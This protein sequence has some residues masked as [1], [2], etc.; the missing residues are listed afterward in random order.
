MDRFTKLVT[1]LT[2]EIV[3]AVLLLGSTLSSLAVAIFFPPIF[4][5]TT[6]FIVA[7]MLNLKKRHLK[8]I[9]FSFALLL[10]S[11][12][13]FSTSVGFHY[14][15]NDIDELFNLEE[16]FQ[17]E[18]HLEIATERLYFLDEK[19]SHWIMLAGILG[20]FLSVLWWTL[21]TYRERKLKEDFEE[22]KSSVIVLFL[23]VFF[24]A[25]FG[26]IAALMSVEAHVLGY[27]IIAVSLML[28]FIIFKLRQIVAKDVVKQKVL[29]F[30][31]MIGAYLATAIAYFI[32][33]KSVYLN[34]GF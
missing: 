32:L 16:I 11:I 30:S 17:K 27:G 12:S 18:M 19:F 25:L 2:I 15:A 34:I 24:G 33:K 13:L 5:I 8:T 10:A 21:T 4:A 1:L 23:P 6:Y 14:A 31:A 7:Y 20:V 22:N 26:T 28:P 29:F 9:N 3:L